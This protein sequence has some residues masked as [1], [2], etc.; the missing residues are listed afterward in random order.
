M[1]LRAKEILTD[2]LT[3]YEPTSAEDVVIYMRGRGYEISEDSLATLPE[4]QI[5]S[6]SIDAQLLQALKNARID[7]L[8][9][10][11]KLVKAGPTDDSK[12]SLD[13]WLKCVAAIEQLAKSKAP[14]ASPVPK[15]QEISIDQAVNEFEK[16]LLERVGKLTIKVEK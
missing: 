14:I 8:R 4:W 13:K 2:Y 10:L 7:A 5:W 6:Q 1:D 11:Q 15:Q 3:R 9:R 16:Q 12:E